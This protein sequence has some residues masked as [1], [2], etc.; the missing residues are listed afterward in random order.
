MTFG[1]DRALHAYTFMCNKLVKFFNS[2]FGRI[3]LS[4]YIYR[5]RTQ[6]GKNIFFYPDSQFGLKWA[7]DVSENNL[8]FAR[9]A[10][11]VHTIKITKTT[12][13]VNHKR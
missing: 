2:R 10:I 12:M 7:S 8:T 6:K 11:C 3:H 1:R 9:R 5:A 13:F 4:P